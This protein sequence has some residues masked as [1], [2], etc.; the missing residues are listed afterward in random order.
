[1]GYMN[2]D[3]GFDILWRY[4]ALLLEQGREDTLQKAYDLCYKAVQE[5]RLMYVDYICLSTKHVKQGVEQYRILHPDS[6]PDELFSLA[7]L[8]EM[9]RVLETPTE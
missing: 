9:V 8:D 7:V 4:A 1:M 6:D 2:S 5:R 3:V